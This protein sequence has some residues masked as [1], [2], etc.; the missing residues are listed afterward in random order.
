MG[1][2]E[3]ANRVATS[4]CAAS[5]RDAR[6]SSAAPCDIAR[7]MRCF[8]GGGHRAP[9]ACAVQVGWF[10]AVQRFPTGAASGSAFHAND[11]QLSR[12]AR[13]SLQVAAATFATNFSPFFENRT[14][15]MLRDAVAMLV[16][17]DISHC[18][19]CPSWHSTSS[20]V[21]NASSH[22]C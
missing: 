11:V 1:V 8:F 9:F 13:R 18:F 2:A 17:F 21:L 16:L 20:E 5:T 4:A 12:L 7:A 19:T 6:N 3:L 10:A 15:I 14:T 22:S